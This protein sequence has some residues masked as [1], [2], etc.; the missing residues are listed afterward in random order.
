MNNMSHFMFQKFWTNSC[1]CLCIY[2]RN[3]SRKKD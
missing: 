1:I 2:C 3:K